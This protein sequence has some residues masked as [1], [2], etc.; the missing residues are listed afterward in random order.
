MDLLDEYG[1][2]DD[3]AA[4]DNDNNNDVF[5]STRN[6]EAGIG[7]VHVERIA[8][9]PSSSIASN[10]F[11][12]SVP[13]IPG[14][15]AGHVFGAI[16][17]DHDFRRELSASLDRFQM[18]LMTTAFQPS[19]IISHLD[20]DYLHLSLS[21]LF[22]LPLAS[23]ESFVEQLQKRLSCIPTTTLRVNWSMER[24]LVNDERTRYFCTVAVDTNP[25]LL[26]M[27]QQID[28]V[29]T[30]YNQPTYYSPPLFHISIASFVGDPTLELA[31]SI[32]AGIQLSHSTTNSD[33]VRYV[34]LNQVECTFGTTKSY[35]VKLLPR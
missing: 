29:L 28:A 9:V 27:V 11:V 6:D 18:F 2:S 10:T 4:D 21:R 17:I 30:T 7:T 1:S 22:M 3:D 14:N 34:T 24:L 35:S 8:V 19:Q 16:A 13:H 15:W 12:R 25:T 20:C 23:I 31:N 5:D 32:T 26:A 33:Y